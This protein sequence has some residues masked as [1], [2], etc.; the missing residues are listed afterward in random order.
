M[1]SSLTVVVD[2][3]VWNMLEWNLFESKHQNDLDVPSFGFFLFLDS[4]KSV[5]YLLLSF[6]ILV[7]LA[8]NQILI[9]F[10]L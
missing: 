9:L 4:K 2:K 3:I 10:D 7:K 8:Y 5:K 1:C 6:H